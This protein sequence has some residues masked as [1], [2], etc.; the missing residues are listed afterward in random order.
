MRTVGCSS[1][2]LGVCAQGVGVCAQG[3]CVPGG[4]LPR[5][6]SAQGV[7][8]QE[9]VLGGVCLGVWLSALWDTYPLWREWQ[10]GVETLTCCN[11]IADGN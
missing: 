1:R 10:T 4:C 7:S 8:A 5:G 2:L 6:V 11:Y 9:G 3:G